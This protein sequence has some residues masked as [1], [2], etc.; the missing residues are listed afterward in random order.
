M[1][2]YVNTQISNKKAEQAQAARVENTANLTG[3]LFSKFRWKW[4]LEISSRTSRPTRQTAPSISTNG[5]AHRKFH[6][7][8]QLCSLQ[9]LV[10]NLE[11]L[12]ICCAS[13]SWGILFSHPADFTPVCTTELARVAQLYPEFERRNVRPIA[14]SCD[15]SASHRQWI[16]DI[17]A[18]SGKKKYNFFLYKSIHLLR[19]KF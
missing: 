6:S 16:E 13:T 12:N 2:C 3:Y 15:S 19:I 8:Q 11:L 7:A 1:W 4:I 10:Y 18:Y 17:K 5:S 14:L 9:F